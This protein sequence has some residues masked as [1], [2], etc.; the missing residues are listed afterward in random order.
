M[1]SLINVKSTFIAVPLKSITC[2][3]SALQPKAVALTV[4]LPEGSLLRK[5]LPRLSVMVCARMLSACSL[6]SRSEIVVPVFRDE[7]VIAVIDVDS[8]G[9]TAFDDIDKIGLEKIAEIISP[10]FG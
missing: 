9:Y 8:K 1:A 3:E 10:L 5:Y 6:K 2:L 4:R 7:E